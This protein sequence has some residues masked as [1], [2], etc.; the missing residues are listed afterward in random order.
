MLHGTVSGGGT[1]M[2]DEV[3][4]TLISIQASLTSI[5]YIQYSKKLI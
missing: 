5:F 1:Q 2:N 3:K 4:I